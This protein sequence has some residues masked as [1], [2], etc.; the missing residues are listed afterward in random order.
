MHYIAWI[1][2]LLLSSEVLDELR[3]TL[4]PLAE[5]WGGIS[6]Q[7]TATYGIR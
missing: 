7:H 1:L 5:E 4:H 3:D 2:F 6:L